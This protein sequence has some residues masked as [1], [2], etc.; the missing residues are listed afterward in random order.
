V[1]WCLI[2]RGVS[3]EF[4]SH[5]NDRVWRGT[6][7]FFFGVSSLLLPVFFGSALGNLLRGVP[8]DREGWFELALFTDFTAREPVGI[9]DWYTI[10]VGV[11]AAAAL[12]AHGGLYLASRTDG[13]V[14]ER[15]RRAGR[16][17][18]AVAAALWPVVTAATIRVNSGFLSSLTARP[19]AWL[20]AAVALCG[21]AACFV[22]SARGADRAAFLGSCGFLVGLSAATAVCVFPV[23]LRATGDPAL[24]MTA[25]NAAGD[26]SGLRTALVWFSIG[27]PIA[28]LYFVI[29]YRLHRGRVVA[30]AEGEGY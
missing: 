2:L 23:M 20:L 5:V 17:L 12:C 9:L 10:L 7:D 11:F 3:I 25:Y 16:R 1:L 30:A 29:V 21:L 8:L 15:S 18:Y 6:W 13:A 26:P 19:L 27:F 28:I 4:R 22:G 24:S 14:R